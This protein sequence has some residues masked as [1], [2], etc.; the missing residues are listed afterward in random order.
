MLDTPRHGWSTVKIGGWSE[1]CS[2]LE[3]VPF[4]LL[5]SLEKACRTGNPAAAKFDAEGYDYIIV[6]DE[7]ETHI[8]TETDTGYELKTVETTPGELARELVAD[9]RNDISGWSRWLDYGDMSDDEL[10]ERTKDLSVLCD[11]LER[12][13]QKQ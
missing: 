5:E 3:D 11:I 13:I 12:R 7:H 1:K 10:Q 2:Y 8:I 6:F 4:L 9:I